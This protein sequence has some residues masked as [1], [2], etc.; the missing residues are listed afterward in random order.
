MFFSDLEEIKNAL[1]GKMRKEGYY[2]RFGIDHST[3]YCDNLDDK[4]GFILDISRKGNVIRFLEKPIFE[5]VNGKEIK[6]I[7]IKDINTIDELFEEIVN[8]IIEYKI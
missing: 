4:F 7:K 5:A 8:A 6:Y 2:Y 1:N 3:I